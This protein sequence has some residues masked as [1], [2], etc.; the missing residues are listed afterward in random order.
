MISTTFF[1]VNT[2][3]HQFYSFTVFIWSM[4]AP[5]RRHRHLGHFNKTWHAQTNL[6]QGMIK[7]FD[8]LLDTIKWGK[9]RVI[10][11]VRIGQKPRVFF[12]VEKSVFFWPR[13]T[14]SIAMR[15]IQDNGIKWGIVF[16]IMSTP[17]YKMI[18]M[19]WSFLLRP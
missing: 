3:N 6:T 15:E 17:I 5:V 14:G 9:V 16:V 7:I 13:R 10:E 19:N 11:R 1:K 18:K 12:S 2:L 4:D 8:I